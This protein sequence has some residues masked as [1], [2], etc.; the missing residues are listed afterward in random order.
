MKVSDRITSPG[1]TRAYPVLPLRDIVVFPHVIA[2]VGVALQWSWP[3]VRIVVPVP[4]SSAAESWSLPT[5]MRTETRLKFEFPIRTR[6]FL[7][8][9]E[10]SLSTPKKFPVSLRREFGCKPL[11]VHKGRK[12]QSSGPAHRRLPSANGKCLL[13]SFLNVGNKLLV[14]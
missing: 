7:F 14:A 1:G 6:K 11:F 12:H 10:N 9:A 3:Q 2:P 8:F 4:T 13:N 5:Q